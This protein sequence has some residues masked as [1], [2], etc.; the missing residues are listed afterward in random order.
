MSYTLKS[1]P[2]PHNQARTKKITTVVIHWWGLPGQTGD[3][4]GTARYLLNSELSV[5]YVASNKT[6]VRM[7]AENRVA[8]HAASANPF[9]VGIECDP[10]MPGASYQTVTELVRDICKRHKLNPR[11]AVKPHN[12]YFNTQCPGSVNWK[13]IAKDAYNLMQGEDMYKGKSAKQ[14]YKRAVELDKS[15]N[16]WKSRY[17]KCSSGEPQTMLSKIKAI[18]GGK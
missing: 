7:V 3:L 6:V 5:H 15:R 17:Q 11:K 12:T 8:Y 14:W 18:L 13:K 2:D 16:L 10:R 9:S 4:M 1:L